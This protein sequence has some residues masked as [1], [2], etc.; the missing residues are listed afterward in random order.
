M[1]RQ[2]PAHSPVIL[3]VETSCDETA[4]AVWA[5][6]KITGERVYSQWRRHRPF[7]GVV[8]ELASR[9]HLRRLLPLL[10]ELLDECGKKPDYL[11]YTAGPGLAGALLAGA[12]TANALAFAWQIPALAVNHLTGHIL[13]PLLSRPGFAFPYIALLISGGHT[14]L[15]RAKAAD[16][17][18]LLG[19][20]LDDAAGE[21]FD[22][23]AV[24]LGL[25]YPGGAKLEKLAAKGEL[26][27][28]SLP[29]PAQKN[30]DFSFSGLKS[31]ARRLAEK[32]P[33][34]GADIAAAF[35]A[36]AA[37]GL[38]KQAARALQKTGANR[39]AVVGGAAQNNTVWRA[40]QKH[41]A[42]AEVRRPKPAHCGDNAA[43]IALAAALAPKKP[44]SNYAFNIYPRWR[45]NEPAPN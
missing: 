8:P 26:G 23:T 4:C 12:T 7:G 44:P 3:A 15:W 19:E 45:P 2:N 18:E 1:P 11:A 34:C 22:K 21:A 31:A 5:D 24:L 28:F 33:H 30:L 13:S 17:L 39:I 38:A 32:H 29:S 40:L 41:C 36:A 25:E 9:D 37:E 42:G 10:S 16:N 6:G 35:Q 14:Q 43:M 20:T 27:K